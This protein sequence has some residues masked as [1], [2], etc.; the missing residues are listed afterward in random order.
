MCEPLPPLRFTLQLTGTMKTSTLILATL[1]VVA[2]LA[3]VDAKKVCSALWRVWRQ[4]DPD[5]SSQ[6]RSP[7]TALR[8]SSPCLRPQQ[9]PKITNKVFFDV[10]IGGEPAGETVVVG[11]AAAP[12]RPLTSVAVCSVTSRCQAA[13]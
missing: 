13:S 2:A 1:C 3:A 5:T 8:T 4:R 6:L 10:E 12:D 7:H 11:G 9:S